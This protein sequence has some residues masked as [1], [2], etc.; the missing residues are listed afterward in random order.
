VD[1]K[2]MGHLLPCRGIW[3]ILKAKP[4]LFT[5]MFGDHRLKKTIKNVVIILSI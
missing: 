5:I 3:K 2:E 4:M 1:S